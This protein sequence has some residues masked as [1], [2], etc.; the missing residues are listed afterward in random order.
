MF[1]VCFGAAVTCKGRSLRYSPGQGNPLGCVVALY[2]GE[3]SEREQWHLPNSPGLS[4]TS[5]T[6]HKQSGPF[7]CWFPGGWFCVCSRTLW[8]SPTN[9]SVR[10]GV[11]PT[12]GN[13]HR[14]Y[15][16]RFWGFI[17]LCWIPGLRGLSRFPVPAPLSARKCGTVRSAS[18]CLTP[19]ALQLLPCCASSPPWLPVSTPPTSLNECFFFNSLVVWHPYRSVFWQFWLFLFLNLLL[20]FW[21]CEEAQR[22]YLRLHLGRKVCWVLLVLQMFP[23]GRVLDNR[24]LKCH[25]K[26]LFKRKIFMW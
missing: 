9:S 8:V 6:V 19:L 5:P 1:F 21:L 24:W 3:G 4:V 14:F 11:S 26:I 20:S 15:H 12:A 7:W 23:W 22:I 25:S 17:S 13:P 2:V 16:Q 18:R 10:L